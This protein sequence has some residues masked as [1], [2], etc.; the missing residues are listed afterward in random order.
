MMAK[1]CQE[2]AEFIGCSKNKVCYWCVHSDPDNLESLKDRRM[3]GNNQKATEQ[4]IKILLKTI[5]KEPE[6]LGYEFGRWSVQRLA[7]YL[8][9]ET[10]IKI[11]SLNIEPIPLIK[12]FE[13]KYE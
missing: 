7:T 6:V 5:E 11:Y 1:P 10:G 3:K 9:E 2:I 13:S 12:F 4:Y 8:E